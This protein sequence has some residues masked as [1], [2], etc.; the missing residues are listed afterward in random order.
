MTRQAL[1]QAACDAIDA[2][3]EAIA[4]MA[5]EL[6]ATPELGFREVSTAAYVEKQMRSLGMDDVR[7]GIAKTGLTGRYRGRTARGTVAVFGELDAIICRDHPCAD[8]ATGAA[9]AC[10]HHAQLVAMLGAAIGLRGVMAQ[11]DGDVVFMG[12][13]AEESIDSDY[14]ARLRAEGFHFL[15][16]KQELYRLGA[17]EG[18]DASLSI[19]SGFGPGGRITIPMHTNIVLKKTTRFIGRQA[20]PGGES[21]LGINAVS[22]AT[23]ALAAI[24]ALRQT[25]RPADLVNVNSRIAYGGATGTIPELCV[26]ETTLRAATIEGLADANAKVDR[27]VRGA[28]AAIGGAAEISNQAGPMQQNPSRELAELVQTCGEELSGPGNAVLEDYACLASDVGDLSQF[29]PTVQ[30]TVAG[31]HD[32]PHRA[33]FVAESVEAAYL[34]PA[35]LMATG[36]IALLCDGAAGLER[37]RKGFR[38]G[39]NWEDY[40]SFWESLSP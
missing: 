19:H 13:P 21:H 29:L 4:A 16:G 12:V 5:E 31:F 17:F 28:A 27:A 36:V 18:I 11:L 26:V 1:S 22:C 7:T 38:P 9:H 15:S 6:L 10:G 14:A 39:F 37:V 23:V 40:V 8:P 34:L 2:G 24:D 25:F 20:H 33:G 3:R 30:A 32:T 35:K